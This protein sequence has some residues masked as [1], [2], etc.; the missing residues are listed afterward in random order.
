LPLA[1]L[2]PWEL[3]EEAAFGPEGNDLGNVKK[4][5]QQ[6]FKPGSACVELLWKKTLEHKTYI[7]NKWRPKKLFL[8]DLILTLFCAFNFLWKIL[9]SSVP[10]PSSKCSKECQYCAI[11]F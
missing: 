5:S 1:C 2:L 10:M 6:S 4:H 7:F 11:I 9:K 8:L 3:N